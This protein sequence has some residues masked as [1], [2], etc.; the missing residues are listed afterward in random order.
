[1]ENAELLHICTDDRFR[2]MKKIPAMKKYNFDLLAK[3]LMMLC[4]SVGKRDSAP[5]LFVDEVRNRSM[6]GNL[7]NTIQCCPHEYRVINFR[8]R[9]SCYP[10]V[11][12]GVLKPVLLLLAVVMGHVG[13]YLACLLKKSDWA[14]EH[15]SSLLIWAFQS[16]LRSVGCGSGQ[17]VYCMSDHNFYSTIACVCPEFESYVLQHGLVMDTT[18]YYPVLADHFLAW[19][20]RSLALM[21]NDPKV[22]VVGTFKFAELKSR[23]SSGSKTILYCV[24]ITDMKVV[25]DKI[26]DLLKFAEENCFKLKV[27]MHPG[28]FYHSNVLE[29]RFKGADIEFFKECNVD[30]IDFE[31]AVIENSTILIDLLFLDKPILIFDRKSGGYFKDYENELPWA[32]SVDELQAAFNKALDGN[33]DQVRE[34]I[35]HNELH[36]GRCSIWQSAKRAIG[37]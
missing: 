23:L 1:M 7:H 34:V 15:S 35:M 33:F 10:H 26:A 9:K 18:Y 28:N 24:S 16:Y 8:E 32:E 27:K 6:M 21:K 37:E 31:V 13:I 29:N 3:M 22:D 11:K 17:K 12:I 20:K 36:D 25:G 4:Q 2:F 30:D 5:V 14:N 19:G